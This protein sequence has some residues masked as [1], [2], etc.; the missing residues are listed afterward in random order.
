MSFPDR[1]QKS[2]DKREEAAKL[3]KNRRGAENR[4]N[5]EEDDYRNQNGKRNFIANYSKGLKHFPI[6]NTS[7]QPHANAGE[8]EPDEYDHL[9]DRDFDDIVF[10]YPI[11]EA[12]PLINPR[13]GLAFDLEGPDSHD[14]AIR[15][16]PRINSAEGAGE[17]AELYWMALCRDIPFRNYDIDPMIANAVSDLNSNTNYT[18]FPHVQVGLL[19]NTDIG[20]DIGD[21]IFAK[22]FEIPIEA[23]NISNATIFRGF[24]KGDLKGP[25]ISQFLW[26]DVPMGTLLIEQIQFELNNKIKIDTDGDGIPDTEIEIVRDYLTDYARWLKI[27]DGFKDAD[28]MTDDINKVDKFKRHIITG[29]DITFYVHRDQLYQAYLNACLILL[30]K[31][32]PYET[33]CP[34]DP[35]LPYQ[36]QNPDAN[37]LHNEMGF[38]TFGG[39]HILSLLAEVAT[40]AGKAIWYHKWFVHRRL[41]PE[42][43]GGLIHRQLN[44]TTASSPPPPPPLT[45]G[46][47][48]PNPAYLINNEILGKTASNQILERIKEHNRQQNTRFSRT[49]LQGSYLLPQAFP[50][51]SPTHPSYGS[52]HATVAGACVT[53][54]KAFFKEDEI[55][56]NP[57]IP[58]KLTTPIDVKDGMGNIIFRKTTEL[59]DYTGPDFDQLTV[60]G[61]LDKLAANISVGRNWAGVHYRSDYAEAM[62]LGEQIALGILQEQADTYDEEF[63]CTLTRFSGQRIKFEGRKITD[64]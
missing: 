29:R 5:G 4:T 22:K 60:G 44:N 61:E 27:Q 47:S 55:I 38:I 1:D 25:Y 2:Y 45:P 54:L 56:K 8:V 59:E 34:F 14:M 35:L 63:T 37:E 42:A 13:A 57:V 21:K 30:G 6:T 15:K 26:Q 10:R 18:D 28:F 36:D 62:L 19:T 32:Y 49:D 7:G 43:F 31:K 16:A 53:V 20:P 50:E 33:D 52:G 39:P 17:M 12:V 64:I 24:T 40:R 41:R 58:K 9:R 48:G 23:R 51:G 11:N 46:L 3:A